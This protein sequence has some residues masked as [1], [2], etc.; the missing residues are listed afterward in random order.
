MRISPGA[1]TP[2]HSHHGREVTLC[3]IGGFHDAR[4]SYGPGDLSFADPELVHQPIADDDGVCFVLAVTDGGLK[5]M[6]LFGVFQ[7]MFGG[8]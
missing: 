8:R 3:L 2:V 6:G 1:K 4:G 5:F 7:K